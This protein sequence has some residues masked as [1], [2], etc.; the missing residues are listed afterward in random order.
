M[1]FNNRLSVE[2]KLESPR[3]NLRPFIQIWQWD[4]E[5]LEVPKFSNKYGIRENLDARNLSAVRYI[6]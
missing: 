6:Q 4:A 3:R 5:K 1:R 2:I